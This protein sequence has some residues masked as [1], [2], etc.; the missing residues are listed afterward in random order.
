[1]ARSVPVCISQIDICLCFDQYF[2]SLEISSETRYMKRGSLIYSSCLYISSIV[3]KHL[4]NLIVPFRCCSI[5]RSLLVWSLVID[6]RSVRL[7][8]KQ[9]DNDLKW[10]AFSSMK[11]IFTVPSSYLHQIDLV[12]TFITVITLWAINARLA[13]GR[14]PPAGNSLSSLLFFVY[15]GFDWLF[16]CCLTCKLNSLGISVRFYSGSVIA[17]VTVCV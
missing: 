4:H 8:L 14:V 6:V 3:Q 7:V 13:R 5:E 12:L 2:S 1:M 16:G 11:K 17:W 15:K 9:V 10:P